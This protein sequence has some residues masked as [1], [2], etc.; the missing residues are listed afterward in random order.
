M[1]CSRNIEEVEVILCNSEAVWERP[2]LRFD[3]CEQIVTGIVEKEV[4]PRV[5]LQQYGKSTFLPFGIVHELVGAK[6]HSRWQVEMNERMCEGQH[7]RTK[8]DANVGIV[9]G[10]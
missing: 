6:G 10:H 9:G 8:T 2:V 4:E 3:G 7:G 1:L 5:T